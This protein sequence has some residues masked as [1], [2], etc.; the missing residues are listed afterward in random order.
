MHNF[1][2]THA[3][4][5]ALRAAC[6]P[7]LNSLD[8]RP[9]LLSVIEPE[10]LSLLTQASRA[11][12]CSRVTIYRIEGRLKL[13]RQIKLGMVRPTFSRPRFG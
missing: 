1:T 6:E 9:E 11:R 8:A 3:A 13:A 2:D 5:E 4:D 10:V 12:Q 7:L